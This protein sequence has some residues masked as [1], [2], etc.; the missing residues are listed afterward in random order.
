MFFYRYRAKLMSSFQLESGHN[1]QQQQQFQAKSKFSSSFGTLQ[2]FLTACDCHEYEK[3]LIEADVRLKQLPRLT[4]EQ[5]VRLGLLRGA[6]IRVADL[7]IR[8]LPE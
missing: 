8:F 5:L 4:E 1:Q 6:A 7:A 2:A 3:T